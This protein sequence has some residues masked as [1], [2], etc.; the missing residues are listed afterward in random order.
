MNRDKIILT[1]GLVLCLGCKEFIEPSV[2]AKKV[3]LLA[4]AS[5]TETA[6]YTQTFWW[7]EV[8]DALSYRLQVV[9]P[10]FEHPTKLVLDT[11]IRTNKFIFSVDPGSYKWRVRAENGSSQ[12]SYSS[13]SIIV[14]PASIAEQQVQ[15]E[16]PGN[17]AISNQTTLLFKWQKLFNADQYR[18]ELDTSSNS[19]EDTTHLF[20]D[21]TTSNL[22]YPVSFT[23]DQVYKWRVRALSGS[24]QSK[25][26]VIQTLI[27]DATP[28]PAPLIISP[29]NNS[30][31]L[32]PV[33]LKWNSVP[34]AN[35]Y[36][37]Y[38]YKNE[39]KELYNLSFPVQ[40]TN[41][42]YNFNLGKRGEQVYWELRAV[43]DVGN[44]SA[45]GEMRQ[46]ILQ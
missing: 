38:V 17:N 26:S 16:S 46:F 5:G 32:N 18:I 22:N 33:T 34:G 45:P 37:L 6:D 14:H 44:T 29:A 8:E 39:S 7:K 12:S 43:D 11:L 28:P 3:L 36:V 19:F 24:A 13:S 41:L 25:W 23:N 20:L 9:S 21:K 42:S 40:T 31:T 2:E 27:R 15:L 30:S 10:T 35:K 4:P 1:V